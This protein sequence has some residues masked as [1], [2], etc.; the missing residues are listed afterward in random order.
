V[1]GLLGAGIELSIIATCAA[2]PIMSY[3]GMNRVFRTSRADSVDGH[4]VPMGTCAAK[5][6]EP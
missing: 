2:V 5:G 6:S 1:S 4:L 3:F